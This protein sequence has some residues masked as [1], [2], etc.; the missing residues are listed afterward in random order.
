MKILK[1]VG[2]AIIVASITVAI[3]KQDAITNYFKPK[4]MSLEEMNF[5]HNSKNGEEKP[6]YQGEVVNFEH[7]GGYTYIEVKEK[8][9]MTFWIAV[10]NAD[11]K[12][13]DYIR[14]QEELV[15]K[16]FKSKALNKIYDELM[17]ASNLEYKVSE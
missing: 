16:D 9:E 17:F 10:E 14:F 1:L 15:M 5:K 7:G 3:I 2:F 4:Q 8:T 11:V 6:F 13:G 12:K